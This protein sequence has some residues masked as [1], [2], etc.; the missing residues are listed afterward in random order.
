MTIS[1]DAETAATARAAVSPKT[2]N[3]LSFPMSE[4]RPVFFRG[5][6]RQDLAPTRTLILADQLQGLVNPVEERRLIVCYG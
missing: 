6:A 3:L 5:R 4:Q 2:A 1:A